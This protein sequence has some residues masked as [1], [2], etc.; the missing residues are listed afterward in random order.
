MYIPSDNNAPS[1]RP[2]TTGSHRLQQLPLDLVGTSH[3]S[4]SSETGASTNHAHNIG[5][6]P[7]CQNHRQVS[8]RAS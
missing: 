1:T 5:R 8:E 2:P 3:S 4:T 7:T 6:R